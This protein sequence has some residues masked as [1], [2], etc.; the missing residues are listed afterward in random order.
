[1]PALRVGRRSD[2]E[3]LGPNECTQ[4]VWSCC[5]G[6]LLIRKSEFVYDAIEFIRLNTQL[7]KDIL[8]NEYRDTLVTRHD[9]RPKQSVAPI[10]S[11]AGGLSF[12]CATNEK[13]ELL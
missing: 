2:S 4:S 10:D 7:S 9:Y 5:P 8:N 1:M 13:N 12:E 6:L 3:L 11:V